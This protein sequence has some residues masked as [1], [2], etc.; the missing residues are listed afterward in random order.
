MLIIQVFSDLVTYICRTEGITD[1]STHVVSVWENVFS[2]F[3]LLTTT[4]EGH[5]KLRTR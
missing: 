5:S 3:V 1:S 4:L 2:F